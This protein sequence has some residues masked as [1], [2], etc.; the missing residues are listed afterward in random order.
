MAMVAVSGVSYLSY[1][2][3]KIVFPKAGVILT[4]ILGGLYS[5]TATT[6]ILAKQR[7]EKGENLKIAP[8]IILAT[9][10][11]YLRILL[12]AYFLNKDIALKLLPAFAVLI[13]VSGVIALYFLKFQKASIIKDA[14]SQPIKS[15]SNPLEFKTALVF[16]LLFIFFALVTEYVTKNYGEGGIKALSFLV[17]VTDIDPFIIN[18]FQSKWNIEETALVTAVIIATSSNDLLKMIYGIILCDKSIR[19][20]LILGFSI[21]II[22]GLLFVFL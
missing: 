15:N 6:I 8:A 7:K 16:A 21:L 3:K 11:M 2:L 13:I 18:L 5:S 20:Q 10:M 9:T 12:L 22:L 17:G 4:G 1:L 19:M 14:T